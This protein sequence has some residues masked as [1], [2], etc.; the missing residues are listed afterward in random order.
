MTQF[1]H[2]RAA[3]ASGDVSR[4]SLLGAAAFGASGFALMQAAAA[5]EAGDDRGSPGQGGYGRSSVQ[6]PSGAKVATHDPKDIAAMPEFKY[7]LD[8]GVP[9]I[10][11]GGWAKESTLHQLPVSKG[12]AGVHM[13]LNPGASRE[14]HWH[15]IAAEWAFVID[16]RCQTMVLEPSGASEINNYEP[17]DL[18]YFA[19]GHG[20]SIQCIGDKPCHFI[21]SFDNGAFSEHGTFSISDWINVTPKDVLASNFN[22]PKD[23]FDA[24]PKGETYIQSGPIVPISQ[25]LDAPWPKESTHKFRL[26]KDQRAVRDF[27]GGTFRLASI[28]EFPA[29][30]TMAGGLMVIN[31]GKQRDLHWHTNANEWHYYLRGKGQV[32]LFGSGGRGKLVDV[33]VG[34]A[35]YIPA[36]FGHAIRN[37]GNEDLEIVQ[38]WD[39]GKFEEIDL[40]RWVRA[41][42]NYLLANNF[43]G[44]PD[45]TVSKMKQT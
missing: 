4:R 34:D 10:T 5:A 12:L 33:K 39:N 31:S 26:L 40:D 36:G 1:E 2:Q 45:S 37:S 8:G 23:L 42:P 6:L 44:V 35:V 14:L 29:S 32:A 38:T 11:S 24:F 28:D 18:W 43:S 41:S 25:A 9:K 13:F 15:A 27:A 17:G 30:R 21:L 22:L 3:T 7:S 19:K 20:H 16:G